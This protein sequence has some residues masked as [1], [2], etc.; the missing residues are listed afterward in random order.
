MSDCIVAVSH[1]C[2][3]PTAINAKSRITRSR[4]DSRPP[5]GEI[6]VAV[7][8]ML[9]NGQQLYEVDVPLLA[10]LRPD[11][12]VTQSQ[13]EVCA[14]SLKYVNDLVAREPA[15]S[16][17]RVI[18]LNPQTMDDVLS[19]LVRLGNELDCPAAAAQVVDD[20]YRRIQNVTSM[21]KQLAAR[22]CPRTVCIEWL[23][24]L[25]L[26][27]NWT[28]ELIALAGGKDDLNHP[29]RHSEYVS[30]QTIIEYDP[31]VLIFAPCGFD[32]ARTMPE[33]ARLI[34]RSE[35]QAI[36]AVKDGRTFVVDGNAYFNR[37]SPRLVD[38][39]EILAYLL[40]PRRVSWPHQ[41]PQTAWSILQPESFGTL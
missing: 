9:K 1:A 8:E 24:P 28:P 13:C 22:D 12:I 33:A 35:W 19:D 17:T 39:L 10:S 41:I 27:G 32:V 15:L 26:A 38:T 37:P 7:H 30:W 25:M 20:L 29:G 11:I 23:D 5:S 21:T 31:E 14:V 2:D 34:N 18:H 4:I 6:D 16:N 3:F 36:T 40:H